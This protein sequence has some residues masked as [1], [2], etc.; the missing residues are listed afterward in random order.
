[1][2][3]LPSGHGGALSTKLLLLGRGGRW[4][5]AGH[6]HGEV[7][8]GDVRLAW[9][10][11]VS[12]GGLDSDFLLAKHVSRMLGQPLG[13]GLDRRRAVASGWE[14]VLAFGEHL[15]EKRF[16]LALIAEDAEGAAVSG[17]GLEALW[18]VHHGCLAEPWVSQPHPLLSAPVAPT[19]RPG[20]LT[21][22]ALPP[23]LLSVGA[24][25]SSAAEPRGHRASDLMPLCGVRA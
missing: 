12:T 21:V 14:R 23:Y 17:V 24:D 22:D 8:E 6:F 9:A 5:F 19:S 18:A 15:A 20:A 7:R 1:M 4:P 10:G 13:T 3:R 11:R 2:V 25:G 16:V